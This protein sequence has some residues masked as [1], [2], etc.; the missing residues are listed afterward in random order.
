LAI[1]VIYAHVRAEVSRIFLLLLPGCGLD[2]QPIRHCLNVIWTFSGAARPQ[3]RQLLRP[4][5]HSP[6]QRRE[7]APQPVRVATPAARLDARREWEIVTGFL[8]RELARMSEI[9]ALQAGAALKIDAAE[10]AYNRIVADCARILGPAFAPTFQPPRQ[11]A[12]EPDP[13]RQS[14]A[15]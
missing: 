7:Q 10:H 15:A 14:L 13:A 6:F 2:V 1:H 5:R 4:R 8:A 12:R 9:A 11:L 3:V